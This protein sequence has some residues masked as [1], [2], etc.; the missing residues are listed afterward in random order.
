MK[1]PTDITIGQRMTEELYR[2]FPGKSQKQI[3]KL[4]GCNRK[5]MYYWQNGAAPSTIFLAKLYYSG[6]D[7]LY[8]LTGKHYA[9]IRMIEVATQPNPRRFRWNGTTFEEDTPCL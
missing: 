1:K 6:G 5:N 3:A 9:R 2:V 7:P 8:V 4:L